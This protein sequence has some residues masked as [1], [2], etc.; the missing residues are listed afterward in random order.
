MSFVSNKQQRLIDDSAANSVKFYDKIT[1]QYLKL[2]QELYLLNVTIIQESNDGKVTEESKLKFEQ[3]RF[4]LDRVVELYR[5]HINEITNSLVIRRTYTPPY[6][7]NLKSE[8]TQLTAKMDTLQQ[9][10]KDIKE[11][12]KPILDKM[13]ILVK[14]FDNNLVAKTSKTFNP[15][16]IRKEYDDSV[17][18]INLHSLI[19]E[20]EEIRAIFKDINLNFDQEE[21][22]LPQVDT[23]KS[24]DEQLKNSKILDNFA[25]NKYCYKLNKSQLHEVGRFPTLDDYDKAIE[26]TLHGI[27]DLLSEGAQI[28]DRWTVNA[29]RLEVIRDALQI[30]NDSE[31]Q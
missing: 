17:P 5:T 1:S 25:E 14:S 13:K 19:F 22:E 12:Q 15:N 21:S 28:K 31:I 11:I 16:S 7:T 10:I 2:R 29:R 30:Y 6:V 3:M 8:F 4:E 23:I 20:Y 26:Q 9:E 18:Q 24:L 27:K